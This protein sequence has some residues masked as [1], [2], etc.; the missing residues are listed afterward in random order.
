M[1]LVAASMSGWSKRWAEKYEVGQRVSVAAL[2]V[3]ED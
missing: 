3:C 2:G 1:E